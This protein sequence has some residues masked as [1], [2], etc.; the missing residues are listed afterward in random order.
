MRYFAVV[1]MMSVF[2]IIYVWQNI[3]VMKMKMEYQKMVNVERE[4]E[5]KNAK[6]MFEYEKLR[7]FKVIEANSGRSGLRKMGPS[8][9]VVIKIDE[10]KKDINNENK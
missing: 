6:L 7:S 3:E 2:V 4:L 10:K 8:D 1:F 9:I 5:E